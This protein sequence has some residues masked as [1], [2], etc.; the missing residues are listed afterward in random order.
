MDIYEHIG[1]EALILRCQLG[2][3]AAFHRI[4]ARYNGPVRYFVHRLVGDADMT[5]DIVQNTWLTV[6]RKVRTLRKPEAFRVWLYRVARN[7]AYS[8]LRARGATV[9]LADDIP[10][11]Q[12][13]PDEDTFSAEDAAAVHVALG[14]LSPAH[15]EVVVLCFLEELSYEQIAEVVHCNLGTVKSRIHYAKRALR[16][17]MEAMTN[18]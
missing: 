5:D 11:P 4:F 18:E 10:A 1:E 12:S 13:A 2:E 7:L 3:E 15:R 16:R 8:A 6:V 14:K 9:E 17:E